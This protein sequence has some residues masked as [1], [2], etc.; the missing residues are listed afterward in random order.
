MTPFRTTFLQ[1]RS[2]IGATQFQMA[3]LLGISRSEVQRYEYGKKRPRQKVAAK[4]EE[5][6]MKYPA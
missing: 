5:L 4:I 3:R 6:M 1:L 2:R